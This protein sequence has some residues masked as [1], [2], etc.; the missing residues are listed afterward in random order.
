MQLMHIDGKMMR[1]NFSVENGVD[2]RHPVN[3]E[4]N[5]HSGGTSDINS[6]ITLPNVAIECNHKTDVRPKLTCN[7]DV[8]CK[9]RQRSG[10]WSYG[11]LE[12]RGCSRCCSSMRNSRKILVGH[13]VLGRNRTNLLTNVGKSFR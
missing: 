8:E 5:G 10:G 6:N 1:I 13:V 4:M 2:L 11:V 12:D 7:A 3:G 9:C